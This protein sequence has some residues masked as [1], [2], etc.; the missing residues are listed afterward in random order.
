M[1]L[2]VAGLTI[3]VFGLGVVIGL[4]IG[5]EMVLRMGRDE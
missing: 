5:L 1:T 3:M 4:L 2:I